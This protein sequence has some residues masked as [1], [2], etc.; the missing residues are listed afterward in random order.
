M[1]RY[2]GGDPSLS[3]R[4]SSEVSELI[5]GDLRSVSGN[6]KLAGGPFKE[7]VQCFQDSQP[8]RKVCNS[9]QEAAGGKLQ[10]VKERRSVHTA[11]TQTCRIL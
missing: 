2:F 5:K 9:R 6:F 8:T 4:R 10:E 1:S 11:D 3:T 7:S